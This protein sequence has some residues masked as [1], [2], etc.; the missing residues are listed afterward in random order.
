MLRAQPADHLSPGYAVVN[1][2]AAY[3]K[4]GKRGMKKGGAARV[5]RGFA[6]T[7]SFEQLLVVD[8]LDLPLGDSGGAKGARN[9]SWSMHTVSVIDLEAHTGAVLRQG[10]DALYVTVLEPA[11]GKFTLRSVEVKL[12]PP[13]DP[14]PAGGVRKL[15]HNDTC[16]EIRKYLLLTP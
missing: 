16:C 14:V 13:Q 3:A 4:Q 5:E 1:M 7:K 12:A 10:D 8:E 15:L 11:A 6:F 9:V 2:S